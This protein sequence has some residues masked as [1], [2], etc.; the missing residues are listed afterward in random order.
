MKAFLPDGVEAL[1]ETGRGLAPPAG[2][3]VRPPAAAANS[4]P[5][6]P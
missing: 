1:P 5:F 3:T 4:V 6:P 2:P